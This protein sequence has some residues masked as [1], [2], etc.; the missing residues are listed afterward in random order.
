MPDK[1]RKY[2]RTVPQYLQYL[3]DLSL[4]AQHWMH[5]AKREMRRP[6]FNEARYEKAKRK[7]QEYLEELYFAYRP[8]FEHSDSHTIQDEV[9]QKLEKGT[10]VADLSFDDC[11]TLMQDIRELQEQLGHTSFESKVHSEQGVGL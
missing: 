11:Q 6:D 7:F 4:Q 1:E 5:K 3:L 10:D 9:G 8:K 2:K